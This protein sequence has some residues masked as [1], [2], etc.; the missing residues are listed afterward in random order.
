VAA[1]FAPC[2]GLAQ[3]AWKIRRLGYLTTNSG[4]GTADLRPRDA[5]RQGLRERGWVEGQNI[6]IE[7][8]YADG[9]L[10]RLPR[11]AEE[12]VHLNVEVIAA[13]PTPSALAARN[14]TRTIPIVGVS[15]TEPVAVGLV[16]SLAHPGGNVTGVTYGADT[17]I[18]G[19][20]LELLKESVPGVRRVALLSNPGPAQRPTVRSVQAAA[21][22][23]G[24]EL[25]LL[26]ARSPDAFAG[27]FAAMVKARAG[28][29]LMVGDSMLF[30]HRARLVDLA[31]EN[32]LPSMSTQAQWVEAGGLMSYGPN[33]PDLYRH[34]AAYVH[35]ILKGARAAD[36]PVEEPTK[37]ELVL[38]SKTART[39]GLTIPPSLLARA[40]QVI[41]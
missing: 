29:V 40:D 5:F 33:L 19:K 28:A 9:G 22:T 7:Y 16:T 26:E 24:I 25:Q 4:S 6:L 21:R 37:F 32:R 17:V 11:L 2:V 38:N 13:G 30:L 20:Q 36:L 31:I 35:K 39:L 3:Q 27:A 8:R 34:A 23:L 1:V 41:E 18:F 12:L 10:D 15:L 14:A